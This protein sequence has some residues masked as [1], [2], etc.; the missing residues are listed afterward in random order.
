MIARK[1]W[2]E[3]RGMTIAYALILELMLLPAVLLWPNLRQGGSVLVEMMPADFL[4]DMMRAM[5]RDDDTAYRAYMAV[6][7]FFKAGNMVGIA[8]AVLM[9]TGIVAREREN[10]TLEFLLARPVSRSRILAG[11]FVVVAAAVVVPLIVTSWTAIPLSR[12]PSV[13]ESLP[14]ADLT[15]AAIHNASF[16]LLILALTTF[17]SV[18]SRSQV[19]TA[20]WIGAVVVVQLAIYFVQEIRI[21][22]GFRLSDFEV[23]G[24]ILAG[25]RS[26]AEQIAAQ[27]GWLWL[28]TAVL[29][30][31]AD[32]AFRRTAL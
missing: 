27:T 17:V 28:A 25:N 1:T 20:F 6:Q 30:V 14:F 16:V 12:L 13:D 29:Y 4:R 5:T 32:R 21:I 3:M 2:R 31:G 9:G 26:F 19:Q 22:S 11:K 24:P 18:L 23:Y 8:A 10:Q 7:M 15:L